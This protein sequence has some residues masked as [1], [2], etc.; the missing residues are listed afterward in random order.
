M[1][2]PARRGNRTFLAVC[3]AVMVASD[4]FILVLQSC[5]V[6]HYHIVSA[7]SNLTF[8]KNFAK[9]CVKFL[10]KSFFLLLHLIS[11]NFQL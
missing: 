1:L 6:R 7:F 2:L 9:F 5:Y 4:E 8:T 11:V 3:I 10:K